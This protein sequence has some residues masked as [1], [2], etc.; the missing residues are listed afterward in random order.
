MLSNTHFYHKLIRKHVILFGNM[1]NNINIIKLDTDESTE[2]Q[3]YKVPIIYAPKDH[4]VTRIE[5]DP[6]FLRSVQTVLPRLSFELIDIKYD[7]DRKQ[8]SLLRMAKNDTA[9]R[10]ASSYM[11]VP[12]DFVFELNLYAKTID[13]GNHVIEQ[14]LPYFAPDYTVTITPVAELGLQKDI[15]IIMEDIKQNVQY[16]GNYDSVRYVYWTMTFVVKGYLFGPVSTPKIIR[17]SIANIYNDPSLLTGYIIKINTGS[18]NGNFQINDTIY[19]GNNYTT[20][21]AYGTVIKWEANNAKLFI[22]GAQ[23]NFRTNNTIRGMSTNAVYNIASFDASPVKLVNITV[24]PDPI[25]AEV[26]QDFGYN[27]VTREFPDTLE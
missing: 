20:A 27:T 12:Y 17:K 10:A 8:N 4:F 21:T 9:T 23:G 24:E 25:D 16:E 14:I 5:S 6:D 11:A 22:A 26:D 19:Q 7:A 1:F 2:T 18:G 15:P 13:D 3:R